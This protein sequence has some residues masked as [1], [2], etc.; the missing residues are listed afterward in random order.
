MAKRKQ[1]QPK[2]KRNSLASDCEALPYCDRCAVRGH[3]GV[4]LFGRELPS[5]EAVLTMYKGICL[6]CVHDLEKGG[7]VLIGKHCS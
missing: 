2:R 7:L 4:Y 5:G 3:L 6:W 1:Q